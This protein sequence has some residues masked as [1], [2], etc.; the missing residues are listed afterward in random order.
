MVLKQENK[1]EQI[2][3]CRGEGCEEVGRTTQGRKER[4]ALSSG[5]RNETEGEIK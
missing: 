2:R 3:G 5:T 1:L 4:D